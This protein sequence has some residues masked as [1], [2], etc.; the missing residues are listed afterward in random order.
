M[1]QSLSED[2]DRPA[3]RHSGHQRRINAAVTR[4]AAADGDG[5][6]EKVQYRW[7]RGGRWKPPETVQ[8]RSTLR[9]RL[10]KNECEKDRQSR[11]PVF[12]LIRTE[13]CMYYL[14]VSLILK[15]IEMPNRNW[16]V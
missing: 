2:S 10:P 4:D 3:R 1:E 8:P 7:P 5:R 11:K 9:S 14:P 15:G 12:T 13:R 6:K 16:V